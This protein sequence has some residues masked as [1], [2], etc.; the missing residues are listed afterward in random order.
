MKNYLTSKEDLNLLSL[1]D[2]DEYTNYSRR[3]LKRKELA[4]ELRHED[5]ELKRDNRLS[6]YGYR[7]GF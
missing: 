4:Y 3:E 7:I 1:V 2:E 6:D 5:E